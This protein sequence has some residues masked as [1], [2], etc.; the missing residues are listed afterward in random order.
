MDEDLLSIPVFNFNLEKDF[1]TLA[2]N[3]FRVVEKPY[4]LVSAYQRIALILDEKGAKIESEAEIN[5]ATEAMEELPQPKRMIFDQP[6]V[7]AFKRIDA[8]VPYFMAWVQNT[9]LMV[10]K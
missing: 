3:V 4:T 8:E 2:G 10:L 1:E 6:F 7:I 9:E 5:V